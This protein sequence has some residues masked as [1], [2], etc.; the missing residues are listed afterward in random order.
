[1]KQ[2]IQP[3]MNMMIEEML[4]ILTVSC[5]GAGSGMEGDWHISNLSL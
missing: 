4:D 1:M 5:G 2:Y 3:E